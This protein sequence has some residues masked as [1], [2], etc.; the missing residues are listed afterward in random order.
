MKSKMPINVQRD[1]NMSLSVAVFG[2]AVRSFVGN[3]LT[4][5]KINQLFN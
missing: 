4:L 5:C 1:M 3:F 2:Y